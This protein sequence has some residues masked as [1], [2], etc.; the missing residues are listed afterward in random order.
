MEQKKDEGKAFTKGNEND[1][2]LKNKSEETRDQ[3]WEY[4]KKP[5]E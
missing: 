4:C 3:K 1:E 5:F 2:R